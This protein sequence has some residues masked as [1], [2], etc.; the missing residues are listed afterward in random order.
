MRERGVSS[1]ERD[2]AFACIA[3]GQRLDGRKP[4]EAR[5]VS[6][7]LGPSWGF[8][9]VYF[10]D[11]HAIAS[12]TIEAVKPS[13]DRPNEGTI[14]ISIELSPASS[15]IAA[16]EAL[17]RSN[18]ISPFF[19]T[20]AAIES[21]V[22]ESRAI[23]TEALCILA[24]VKVWAVRVAVDVTN[25]DGN[26]TDV[27][28]LAIMASLL[29]ARRPDVTVTGTE[30]RVHKM[31]E[32]EPVALPVHHVPLAV[33][34]SIF[35]GGTPYENDRT[36]IDPSKLEEQAS[37]GTLSFALN[38]QGEVCGVHKAGGLPLLPSTFAECAAL[39]A[40]RIIELTRILEK[41]MLHAAADHPLASSR[42]MLV[43]VEP[44]AIIRTQIIEMDKNDQDVNMTSM[45]AWNATP[46]PDEFPPHLPAL[47][48]GEGNLVETDVEE[49]LNK[50]ILKVDNIDK[51]ELLYEEVK[52]EC[53]VNVIETSDNSEDES[54]GDEDLE[55]AI[56]MKHRK[57]YVR[58]K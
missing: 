22:R 27:A 30:V 8:A 28:M 3:E 17:S 50:N 23:D 24:G 18:T 34:F 56:L 35:G 42:P 7:K 1:N 16:R 43:N 58:Q 40:N 54:S 47:R 19:E 38:A 13:S 14:A 44:S 57:R 4:T 20:R 36:V 15:E 45:S 9:E 26:C 12:T 31:D 37:S 55:G 25:D 39:G 41:A 2:F 10:D 6:V 11:S 49:T 32:R 29:H 53:V 51:G 33:T 21:F 46:V 48:S 52:A 5:S